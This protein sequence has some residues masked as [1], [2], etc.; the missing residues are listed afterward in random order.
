MRISKAVSLIL[1]LG[2]IPVALAL[3]E[4]GRAQRK[5]ARGGA[6][7]EP[8]ARGIVQ[9]GTEHHFTPPGG[10]GIVRTP[11]FHDPRGHGDIRRDPHVVRFDHT[12]WHAVGHWDRWY[13]AD[14]GGYWRVTDWNAIRTVTCEAVNTQTQELFPVSETRADSWFWNTTLVNNVAGRALDECMT[15]GGNPDIC[16]LVQAECWNSIY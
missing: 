15:E 16:V 12:N 5:P 6:E 4:G 13:R 7:E 8:R 1:A 10:G 2:I 14:W 3:A 11:V 9:H